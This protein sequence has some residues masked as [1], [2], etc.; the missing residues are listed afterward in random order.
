MK[1]F[2]IP[3]TVSEV[4]RQKK[5]PMLFRFLIRHKKK[6]Q[7]NFYLKNTDTGLNREQ[8]LNIVFKSF[9]FSFL[10]LFVLLS[11]TFV[12]IQVDYAF[13]W[14]GSIALVFSIFVLFSQI[15]YPKLYVSRKERNIEKNL[16]PALQ[17]MEVQLSSGVPLFS[18]LVN[19]SSAGYGQLSKEFKKAVVKINAGLPQI[20]VLEELGRNNSSSFFRRTLW[21]ISNGM[22]AGSD[23]GI[24][25]RE[26]VKA[27]TNEQLIQIQNYGNKLNPLIMFYMLISVIMPALAI[28][29]LTIIT[30]LVNTAA[31]ITI[32]MYI[33]LYVF[34]MLIQVMFIGVIRSSRPSLM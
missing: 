33:G 26:S 3:F 30:S 11:T 28:A 31:N 18:I 27:L 16:I 12:L 6:S 5:K 32:M 13:V 2:H 7:L 4:D 9:T 24:V 17:D 20:D 21:Q 15:M 23:I 14:S 1:K 29:F 8:Y 22:K 19:I 34:V 25:I 10:V